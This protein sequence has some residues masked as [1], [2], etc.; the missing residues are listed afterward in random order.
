MR[1]DPI[2]QPVAEEIH[3]PLA[4]R[5]SP[6]PW[7]NLV[8]F[9]ATAVTTT[10]A[11]ALNAGVPPERLASEWTAGLPFSS[12][13]LA[14]LLAHEMGH[15]LTARAHGVRATLPFF[16][17]APPILVG[18]FGAFIRIQSPPRNRRVLFDIGA[19]GPWAGLAVALPAV[20]VGL[21]MSEL[22]SVPPDFSGLYFGDSLLFRGISRA[23]IGPVP[24]GFD[25]FLHPVAMAGWFGLFVTVLNLLPVGQLDGGHVVYAMFGRVHRAIA[26]VVLL[27]IVAVG[28]LGW[29]GWFVWAVLLLLV[30]I[31]H[32]PTLD[33][34]TPLD[35]LRR[36]AGWATL[37]LFVATFVPVPIRW[38]EGGSGPV[39]QELVPVGF[40]TR[41]P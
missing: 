35:P 27:A 3:G 4:A 40:E 34:T 20:I 17:P 39:P 11:G 41:Q 9:A 16:L 24:Y 33:R 18:T 2:P 23:V 6:L 26:R 38:V 21:E 28:F 32:P 7:W 36:A 10:I 31:D 22:K 5:R 13:L 29:N 25:V 30:G 37:A 8:L 12:T 15:Y 1:A 14:I 19:A